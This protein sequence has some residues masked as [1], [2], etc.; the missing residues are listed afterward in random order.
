MK[1][2]EP[3]AERKFRILT[4]LSNLRWYFY[5]TFQNIKPWSLSI[6]MMYIFD[7][8]KTLKIIKRNNKLTPSLRTSRVTDEAA[9]DSPEFV[10]SS[11]IIYDSYILCKTIIFIFFCI[12]DTINNVKICYYL[13]LNEE[14]HFAKPL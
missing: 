11:T 12:L 3:C 7:D 6:S 13:Y 4:T 8:H 1:I 5:I 2:F 14:I 10:N 9:A